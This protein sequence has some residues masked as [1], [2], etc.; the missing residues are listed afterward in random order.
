M[1]RVLS[2]PL[3]EHRTL[4][5][6]GKKVRALAWAEL[7]VAGAV[8][9]WCTLV[10]LANIALFHADEMFRDEA[11]LL[12]FVLAAPA[13]ILFLVI[14]NPNNSGH[15]AGGFPRRVLR[16]PVP[17]W[18]AVAIALGTRAVL[19]FLSSV[20][21]LTAAQ[22]LFANGPAV[23]LAVFY[24]LL[25]LIAQT[26]DWLRA[27]VSGLSS[28]LAVMGLGGSLLFMVEFRTAVNWLAGVEWM[29]WSVGLVLVAA[30]TAA[31][32]GASVFA[33][34]ATRVGLRFGLP[35]IWEWPQYV[36]I[37][38]AP[39]R[40]PFSSPLTAQTWFELR[41]HGW[42]F[43]LAAL[44]VGLAGAGLWLYLA[45]PD[46]DQP[47]L[48]LFT[49]SIPAILL[50]ACAHG[51]ATGVLGIREAG[52]KPEF[53]HRQP[54]TSADA[55]LAVTLANAV[56]LLLAVAVFLTLYLALAA[57][58][59]F[60][61]DG[62]LYALGVGAASLREAVWI[63]ASRALLLAVIVWPLMAV[64]TRGIRYPI[65]AVIF[66]GAAIPVPWLLGV[67]Q[68]GG[69]DWIL[70]IGLIVTVLVVYRY[71]WRKGVIT[72]RWIGI[73]GGLWLLAAW[74]IFAATPRI[75]HESLF[76]AAQW[77]GSA[78]LTSL[79]VAALVPLPYA[80][81][82]I[83]IHRRRHGAAP[84]QDAEQHQR[85]SGKLKRRRITWTLA[86]AA[87]LFVL[88]LGWPSEPA[89]KAYLRAQGEPAS[90]AELNA[91]Y[92]KASEDET[93]ALRYIE[94][95]AE[96][97]RRIREFLV[98]ITY[99]D[100]DVSTARAQRRVHTMQLEL[101]QEHPI[102]V[103][104]DAEL[105]RT[106]P[107]PEKAWST[108]K[109]YWEA[110]TS[111]IAP[112]LVELSADAPGPSRY[113][114]D[115]ENI[116]AVPMG[117]LERLR[118]LARELQLDAL[119]WSV[120]GESAKAVDSTLA[121]IALSASLSEKP[122]LLSQHTRISILQSALSSLD[123]V[124][125]RAELMDAD[126]Q[127]LREGFR[128]ALPPPGEKRIMDAA[129]RGE[130][131]RQIESRMRDHQQGPYDPRRHVEPA[132]M[133]FELALPHAADQVMTVVFYDHV[134]NAAASGPPFAAPNA[135]QRVERLGE[136]GALPL[137][138][139]SAMM[140][141]VMDGAYQAEWRVRMELG[142]AQ[143]TVAVEQFRREH[144][145]LPETLDELVPE[146]IDEVPRDVYTG[147]GAP[148]RY[149]S[150]LDGTFRIYSVGMNRQDDGGRTR[151]E[152]EDSRDIVFKVAGPER[153]GA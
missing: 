44:G 84:E 48:A 86:G 55:A 79:G 152:D 148:V 77:Y 126:L 27:P 59:H 125:N 53:Q 95:G 78:A 51:V 58:T 24:V 107:L 94:I 133:L 147:D 100:D 33:V 47:W 11:V 142:I 119:Y 13:V 74:L 123:T 68:L 34:N 62:L 39:D 61:T 114:F 115:F 36:S 96:H 85:T 30:C 132:R 12:P 82:A 46:F 7:R 110:V 50:G 151:E 19:V 63:F 150:E 2:H 67:V 134:M 124:M 149:I 129:M 127:R 3:A 137:A 146:F 80:A 117:P 136:R 113:P 69:W 18:S 45:Y 111:H 17:V 16:L 15:L 10:V 108:T 120:Q 145:R 73:W 98:A 57:R 37:T 140:V 103:T 9:V 91:F 1:N 28:L 139:Y 101:L 23:S 6:S 75:G 25:Y 97:E 20:V 112:A 22:G 52:R 122:E 121:I 118:R 135:Y 32:Y 83:D 26:V 102:F 88:W 128:H 8:A 106:G 87:V 31:T 72:P 116:S 81:V 49:I 5:G 65:A 92:T 70:V 64:G 153:R 143:A 71:A 90:L 66:I 104:G 29:D 141:P 21:I 109:A 99:N 42:T 54:L 43:P 35:E 130:R 60:L 14:L 76:M 4:G 144:E 89:Y 105:P 56:I 38:R 40:P 131:T 41:R 138:P 93:L